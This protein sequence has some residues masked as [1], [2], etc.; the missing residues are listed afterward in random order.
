MNPLVEGMREK[1]ESAKARL[2]SAQQRFQAAQSELQAATG[3]YG[4]W[5]SAISLLM[6]EEEKRLAESA[7]KQIPMDLPGINRAADGEPSDVPTAIANGLAHPAQSV[8]MV[9]QTEKVREILRNHDTGITPAG[10]WEEGHDLISS[11]AYLYAILKRLR[12]SDEVIIRRGKYLLK[13]NKPI[14]AKEATTSAITGQ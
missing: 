10:I 12:D 5:N 11:R 6:R 2:F 8:T 3:E 7:E 1:L 9:N 14:E 13:I 4:I